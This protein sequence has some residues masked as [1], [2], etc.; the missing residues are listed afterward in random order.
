MEPLGQAFLR[1]GAV[2]ARDPTS[3]KTKSLNAA[4]LVA[5]DIRLRALLGGKKLERVFGFALDG[6]I[7]CD[8]TKLP[9]HNETFGRVFGSAVLHHLQT[10]ADACSEIKRV[11][12]R[13]GKYIGIEDVVNRN[14]RPFVKVFTGAQYRTVPE[15]VRE[16]MYDSQSW[17]KVFAKEGC[18][19][20][21]SP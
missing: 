15:G 7:C 9:F 6:Y 4:S 17:Q 12:F 5:T 3:S 16:D 18:G 19:P 10:P 2:R 20:L 1:S 14:L 8:C 21:L 11:L 13:N